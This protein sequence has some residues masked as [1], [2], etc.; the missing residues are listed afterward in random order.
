[1]TAKGPAPGTKSR[2]FKSP[3]GIW[4][5]VRLSLHPKGP[6]SPVQKSETEGQALSS[7]PQSGWSEHSILISSTGLPR[8]LFIRKLCLIEIVLTPLSGVPLQ[9]ITEGR[10]PGLSSWGRGCSFPHLFNLIQC[11]CCCQG[12]GTWDR[13]VPAWYS[14]CRDRPAVGPQLDEP[15]PFQELSH[16]SDSGLVSLQANASDDACVWMTHLSLVLSPRFSWKVKNSAGF[17]AV[18]HRRG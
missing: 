10:G 18:Q 11:R 5:L 2:A 17:Q 16:G 8:D 15:E 3:G 1:M 6:C 13:G 4:K 9:F 7:L 14:Q 12:R